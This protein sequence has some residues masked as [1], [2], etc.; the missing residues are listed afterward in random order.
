MDFITGLPRTKR[1]HNAIWVV[2]D[3]LS[4]VAHFIPI[5]EAITTSQLADLYV[6]QRVNLH[7]VPKRKSEIME[8]CSF[9]SSGVVCKKLWELVSLSVLLIIHKPVVRPKE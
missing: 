1:G 9:L 7:G 8:A 2:V 4:K 3:R 6:S 5:R